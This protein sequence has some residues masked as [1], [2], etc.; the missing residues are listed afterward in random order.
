MLRDRLRS[1]ISQEQQ[2]QERQKPSVSLSYASRALPVSVEWQ[3][4]NYFRIHE[5]RAYSDVSPIKTTAS[6]PE[7][8][9]S[10]LDELAAT[11][12]VPPVLKQ[13][14]AAQ[15][16]Q[17]TAAATQ[18]HVISN[19]A[20]QQLLKIVAKSPVSLEELQAH[21]MS[22]ESLL[23]VVRLRKG[24]ALGGEGGDAPAAA[25]AAAGSPV[26]SIGQ[27]FWVSPL[28]LWLRGT[29]EALLQT[30]AQCLAKG[31]SVPLQWAGSKSI[32]SRCLPVDVNVQYVCAFL[33]L[34]TAAATSVWLH[35]TNMTVF[36]H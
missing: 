26:V 36:S 8:G 3:S 27:H 15:K 1:S 16:Q 2:Q 11:G 6:P 31:L 9:V 34:L 19:G 32:V 17:Q 21:G 29:V 25:A 10:L 18:D 14:K 12:A 33:L 20:L 5:N 23:H 35:G 13:Q 7:T 22:P 24:T 28:S 30:T 4:D